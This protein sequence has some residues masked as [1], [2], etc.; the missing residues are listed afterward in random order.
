MESKKRYIV[1]CTTDWYGMDNDYP[2]LA[3]SIEE[4]ESIADNL[5]IDNLFVYVTIDELAEYLDYDSDNYT[6]EEW[7][8]L[9]DNIDPSSYVQTIIDEFDGD[10]E[11]WEQLINDTGL[12]EV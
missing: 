6:F 9:L 3:N 4:V 8:D 12:N 7:V 11:K 10:D 1:H 5:A 2:V